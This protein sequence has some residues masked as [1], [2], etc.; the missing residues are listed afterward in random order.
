MEKFSP[1]QFSHKEKITWKHSAF[2]H[3]ESIW[4]CFFFFFKLLLVGKIL[5]LKRSNLLSQGGKQCQE[6]S[7]TVINSHLLMPHVTTHGVLLVRFFYQ[8]RNTVFYSSA[9]GHSE[10]LGC[11]TVFLTGHLS[12][13]LSY[14][15]C[16]VYPQACKEAWS[17][18]WESINFND[19]MSLYPNM[20]SS[21]C[22]TEQ[23]KFLKVIQIERFNQKVLCTQQYTIL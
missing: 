23:L 22:E 2:S 10:G 14:I 8:S 1:G 18:E 12:L 6:L 19:F 11:C 5:D 21:I 3:N 20:L 13:R 17:M 16:I 4:Q 15:C 9:S 7:K